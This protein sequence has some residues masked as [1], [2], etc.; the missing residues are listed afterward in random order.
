MWTPGARMSQVPLGSCH[1]SGRWASRHPL[2]SAQRLRPHPGFSERVLVV[3]AH[4]NNESTRLT[5]NFEEPPGAPTVAAADM[6]KPED[7][8]GTVKPDLL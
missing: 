7:S 4:V 3:Q 8:G 6:V 1:K 5:E 2:L